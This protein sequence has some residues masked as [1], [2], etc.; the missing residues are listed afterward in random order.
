MTGVDSLEPGFIVVWAMEIAVDLTTADLT[1]GDIGSDKDYTTVILWSER[2]REIV[3]DMLEKGLLRQGTVSKAEIDEAIASKLR[4]N[5]VEFKKGPR[6]AIYDSV[7]LKG[8]LKTLC[9]PE[10]LQ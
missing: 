5:L 4:R 10:H 6:Q 1:A 3:K 7:M 9:P 2:S 8:T